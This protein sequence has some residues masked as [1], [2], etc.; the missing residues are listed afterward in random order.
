MTYNDIVNWAE[1]KFGEMVL[2]EEN[3]YGELVISTGLRRDEDDPDY[4]LP[5]EEIE[6]RADFV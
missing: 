2:V 6:D 1:E 4:H 3:E 5:L